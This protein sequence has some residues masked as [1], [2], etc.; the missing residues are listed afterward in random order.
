MLRRMNDVKEEYNHHEDNDQFGV[1]FKKT[2]R[3]L[4]QINKKSEIQFRELEAVLVNIETRKVFAIDICNSVSNGY[5]IG[6]QHHK[7]FANK[8]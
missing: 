1:E 3:K 7:N 2:L 5:K 4:L 6:K 8:V